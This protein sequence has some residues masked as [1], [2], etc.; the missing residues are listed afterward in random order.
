MTIDWL[1]N[2]SIFTVRSVIRVGEGISNSRIGKTV[3]AL[4]SI[5]CKT[6]AMTKDLNSLASSK[7]NDLPIFP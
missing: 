6:D 3:D 2:Q 1:I 7:T 4:S 5:V